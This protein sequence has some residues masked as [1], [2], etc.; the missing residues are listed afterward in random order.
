MRTCSSHNAAS[1]VDLACYI[2]RWQPEVVGKL[3]GEAPVYSPDELKKAVVD[4]S[5]GRVDT[6]VVLV[7]FVQESSA[8]DTILFCDTGSDEWIE[9]PLAMIRE[10]DVLAHK[11]RCNGIRLPIVKV[12]LNQPA[13][14]ESKVLF[15]LLKSR[16][17]GGRRFGS[18]AL[19]GLAGFID[20]G[21]PRVPR[22]PAQTCSDCELLWIICM[23]L[24]ERPEDIRACMSSFLACY[25]SCI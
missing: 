5:L 6:D 21:G 23:E 14:E 13:H 19:S 12:T 4:D 8:R 17:A 3:E 16:I 9:L 10:A 18:N 20:P 15:S 22:P 11:S 24:A 2:N 25:D 1:K 7:G